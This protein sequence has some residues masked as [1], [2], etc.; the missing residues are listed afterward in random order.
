MADEK[1][2]TKIQKQPQ[3]S[4]QVKDIADAAKAITI[5]RKFIGQAQISVMADI[6]R[7]R[8]RDRLA[9]GAEAVK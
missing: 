6:C 1:K 9:L 7:S 5:L 2:P 3:T 4:V 8:C